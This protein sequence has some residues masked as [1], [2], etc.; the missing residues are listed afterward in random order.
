MLIII[1]RI[2]WFISSAVTIIVVAVILL[3]IVRLIADAMDL[4]PF[5]WTSRTIR[6]LTDGLVI[7]VRAGLRQF[8]G[9]DPRFAP[10]A[11]ILLAIIFRIFF[12]WLL[13]TV[14]E[15]IIGVLD[16]TQ[17]GSMA[18]VLAYILSGLL[19]LYIALIIIRVALS[20]GRFSYRNRVMRFLVDVTEPL[21]GPL[22]RMIPPIGWV[23]ISPMVAIL[24]VWICRAA[25]FG[26]LVPRGTRSF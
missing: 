4:N 1:D 9:M 22:R 21:L 17:R 23:D 12:L 24:I 16:S 6:R 26:M 14:A 7:P 5:G 13:E 19:S 10:I 8:R 11:I 18:G 15:T 2:V 3:M 20:W 25:L